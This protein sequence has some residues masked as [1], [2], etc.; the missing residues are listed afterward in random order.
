M[1]RILIYLIAFVGFAVTNAQSTWKPAI[2]F[3]RLLGEAHY[4]PNLGE[5][6]YVQFRTGPDGVEW[7]IYD[8]KTLS[9]T[10]TARWQLSGPVDERRIGV[11]LDIDG[12]GTTD[13]SAGYLVYLDVCL[14]T[15]KILPR[16]IGFNGIA[17]IDGN[18]TQEGMSFGPD[19]PNVSTLTPDRTAFRRVE[20]PIRP[21]HLGTLSA[22][23][24]FLST[25]KTENLPI[26]RNLSLLRMDPGQ[27]H[28]DSAVAQLSTVTNTGPVYENSNYE[29][30]RLFM[31]PD[32][33]YLPRGDSMWVIPSSDMVTSCT[34]VFMSK[35]FS[36]RIRTMYLRA[37][38]FTT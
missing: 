8:M 2:V 18:G 25:S 22:S 6:G 11:V 29:P 33:W 36:L 26:R 13:V 35:R 32:V 3:S 14:P 15:Q 1:R 23:A 12:N 21:L 30:E 16:N 28:Q 4:L 34:H 37:L 7:G 19:F 27:L 10:S 9:D 24:R 20:L 17:D 5:C 38:F 31:F